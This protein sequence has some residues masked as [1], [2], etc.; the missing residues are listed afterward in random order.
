M[1][2]APMMGS[3]FSSTTWPFTV[4]TLC[5]TT[6]TPANGCTLVAKRGPAH[7]SDTDM[8]PK[9]FITFLI[10]TKYLGLTNTPVISTSGKRYATQFC[11]TIE[12]LPCHWEGT[13][14]PP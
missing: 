3:P 11:A 7:A 1:T 6:V 12:A 14:V 5:C 10:N 13:S 8:I 4:T 2:L 9:Y